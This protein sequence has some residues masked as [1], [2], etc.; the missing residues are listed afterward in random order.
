MIS[1]YM[2]SYY[3]CCISHINIQRLTLVDAYFVTSSLIN[4][5]TI[6]STIAFPLIP[7]PVTIHQRMS[8]MFRFVS[9]AASPG[10]TIVPIAIKRAPASLH[11]TLT[12]RRRGRSVPSLGERTFQTAPA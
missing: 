1:L 5:N 12:Y 6:V 7:K 4:D 3:S 10:R 11:T 9:R 2:L 8:M